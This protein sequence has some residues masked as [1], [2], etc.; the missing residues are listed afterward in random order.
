MVTVVWKGA[1]LTFNVI[2]TGHWSLKTLEKLHKAAIVTLFTLEMSVRALKDPYI[3]SHPAV[4]TFSRPGIPCPLCL[5]TKG[6]PGPR[7]SFQLISA[8]SESHTMLSLCLWWKLV[9][10][11]CYSTS[12][13]PY[14]S[15]NCQWA[16]PKSCK[17]SRKTKSNAVLV[18]CENLQKVYFWMSHVQRMASIEM[19]ASEELQ[20]GS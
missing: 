6:Q 13:P 7:R 19:A 16:H 2:Y 14:T 12:V 8:L 3:H 4:M 20:S 1:I 5:P 10:I 18:V 15:W 17:I 9:V 11:Y